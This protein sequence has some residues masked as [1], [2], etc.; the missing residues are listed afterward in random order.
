MSTIGVIDLLLG[1]P[2]RALEDYQVQY[3]VN[4]DTY[5]IENVV[6]VQHRASGVVPPGAKPLG[7]LGEPDL[8]LPGVMLQNVATMI[9]QL[10]DNTLQYLL[11]D[12]FSTRQMYWVRERLHRMQEMLHYEKDRFQRVEMDTWF[13]HPEEQTEIDFLPEPVQKWLQEKS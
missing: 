10:D 3:T 12:L 11:G 5:C 4:Y 9:E 1:I 6:A 7:G 8:H 13:I 2:T